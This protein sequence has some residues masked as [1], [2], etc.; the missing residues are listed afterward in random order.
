MLLPRDTMLVATQS[1]ALRD[2]ISSN[3]RR[4]NDY[5]G[6]IKTYLHAAGLLIFSRMKVLTCRFRAVIR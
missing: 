6:K 4:K 3:L 5:S 2:A 1:D